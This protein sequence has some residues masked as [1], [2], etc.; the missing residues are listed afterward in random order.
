MVRSVRAKAPNPNSQAPRHITKAEWIATSY[1]LSGSTTLQANIPSQFNVRS[2]TDPTI[3]MTSA[4]KRNREHA[5]GND[6]WEVIIIIGQKSSLDRLSHIKGGK[7]KIV[8][9]GLFRFSLFG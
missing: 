6:D 1:Q 2:Q 5:K 7:K 4:H 8:K 9:M 3:D